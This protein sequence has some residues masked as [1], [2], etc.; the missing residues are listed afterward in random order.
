[1]TTPRVINM[2]EVAQQMAVNPHPS[3]LYISSKHK[4]CTRQEHKL[5]TKLR[6]IILQPRAKCMKVI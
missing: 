1:M 5:E 4:T 3:Q 2:R 6:Y